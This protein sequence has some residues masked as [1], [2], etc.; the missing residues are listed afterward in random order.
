MGGA[1]FFSHCWLL[2][3]NL[4]SI[5]VGY[6]GKNPYRLSAMENAQQILGKADLSWL[7][8]M[9]SS[10]PMADGL[11]YP[12]SKPVE[13]AANTEAELSTSIGNNATADPLD[14][15]DDKDAAPICCGYVNTCLS[16]LLDVCWDKRYKAWC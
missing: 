12:I 2:A 3:M 16:A 8:P 5:E 6:R 13:A 11:S 10:R 9:P 4:T 7:L 15:L 14:S 1:L